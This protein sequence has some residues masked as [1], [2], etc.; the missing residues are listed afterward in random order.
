M[1]VLRK[2]ASKMLSPLDHYVR[3]RV[4]DSVKRSERRT[5][6]NEDAIKMALQHRMDPIEDMINGR[7]VEQ[8]VPKR[9]FFFEVPLTDH[10]NLNCAYCSHF[11]PLADEAFLDIEEYERDISRLEVLFNGQAAGVSLVGGEPLINKDIVKFI[12][13]TRKHLH[14]PCEQYDGGIGLNIV[15]NGLLLPKMGEDFW[16]AC[17]KHRV[18]IQITRY[19]INFDYDAAMN[20]CKEK[21]V[22]AR[23]MNETDEAY[24][25]KTKMMHKLRLDLEGKQSITGSFLICKNANTCIMLRHGKLYTCTTAAC[26]HIIK[27]RF[28]LDIELS[29]DDGVDIYTAKSDFEIMERLARPIPFCKYCNMYATEYNHTY[30][31][32][33]R[34][35]D[36]WT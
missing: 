9:Y 21:G 23:W 1:G 14:H 28:N 19:P 27:K 26:A 31:A 30:R 29:P 32:S 15:T 12:E 2:V 18:G 33:N 22:F 11:S 16:E 24:N 6:R 13:V 17:R 25:I 20:L 4:D 8:C 35:L 7:A 3:R 5:A 34:T 10:C 36:E